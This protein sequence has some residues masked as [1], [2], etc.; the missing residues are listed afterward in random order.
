MTPTNVP[1]VCEPRNNLKKVKSLEFFLFLIATYG[2]YIRREFV[3]V[4][5]IIP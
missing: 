4:S 1:H 5:D 3:A 2:S